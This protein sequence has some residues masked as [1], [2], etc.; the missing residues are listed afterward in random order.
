MKLMQSSLVVL[1]ILFED[2][3]HI[4]LEPKKAMPQQPF[5]Q[6]QLDS[7]TIIKAQ[8]LFFPLLFGLILAVIT[9]SAFPP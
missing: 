7:S 1:L 5:L 3:F 6:L 9:T 8:L 2:L 4:I